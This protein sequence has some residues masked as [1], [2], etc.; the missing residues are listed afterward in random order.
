MQNVETVPIEIFINQVLSTKAALQIVENWPL[1]S[2][3]I[4]A[5]VVKHFHDI[6][7]YR[8]NPLGQ[9]SVIG[10]EILFFLKNSPQILDMIDKAKR[11]AAAIAQRGRMNSDT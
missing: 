9:S 1:K 5:V 8:V 4:T 2:E 3:A 11:A 7:I 6:G 10:E